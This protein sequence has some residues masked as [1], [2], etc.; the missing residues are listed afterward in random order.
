MR[1]Y[2]YQNQK[3]PQKTKKPNITTAKLT[4]TVNQE[5]KQ[6]VS[7]AEQGLASGEQGGEPAVTNTQGLRARVQ[8]VVSARHAR[9][10]R[11]RGG[12]K[13]NLPTSKRA[14]CGLRLRLHRE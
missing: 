11:R 3:N 8:M 1:D 5:R 2:I 9:T 4:K 14:S 13:L 7:S 12:G 10:P 6:R